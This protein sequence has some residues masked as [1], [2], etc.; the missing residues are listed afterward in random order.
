MSLIIQPQHNDEQSSV[1]RTIGARMSNKAKRKL[2]KKGAKAAAKIVK[3]AA[4]S[5]GSLLLKMF[6]TLVSFLGLPIILFALA[7]VV[8]VVVSSLAFSFF[9]TTGEG[10]QGED[11]A[12]Y[13]YIVKKANSTVDMNNEW[14]RPYRVPEGLIAATI[15]LDV[16]K[17]DDI[18]ELIDTMAEKLAPVFE[19]GE[20][21]EWT[22]TYQKIYEDGKL[23]KTTEVKRKDNWVKKLDRADY[24]NGNTTFT[25][26]PHVTPWESSEKITYR[27]EKYTETVIETYI[28]YVEETYYEY[29]WVPY[30]V[31]KLVSYT[32][33]V[34]VIDENGVPRLVPVTKYK[35]EIVIEYR[36]EKVEKKRT[37][38]V[39][40]QREVE[41][42]KTRKIE[43]KTVTY[44]RKQYFTS[45]QK[46]VTDYSNFDNVLNSFNLGTIDKKIIEANYAF[47]GG[48]INYIEWLEN[49]G[50]ISDDYVYYD[51]TVIPGESVPAQFMEFYRSAEKKYGVPWYVLAA[52]HFVET[53]FST[54]PTMISSAGAIGPMQF[55]PATWVGWKYS[56]GRGFVSPDIDITDISLIEKGGGYGVDANGDGKADPWDEADAIHAA[57]KMLKA[58]GFTKN[59]RGAIRKYNNSTV[60]VDTVL[61]YAEQFKYEASYVGGD[62]V[63]SL[64][65]GGFMRPAFGK[66]TSPFGVRILNGRR[67]IHYGV[68]IAAEGNVKIVAAADGVVSRSY[69]SSSYGEVV[70]IKHNINGQAYETVYAHMVKGSRAVKEGQK[71]KQGQFLG[72]M[73]ATG[74]VTGKHLHFEIHQGSWNISKSNAIN[75]ALLIK[76]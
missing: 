37:V 19:Y 45:S 69:Y 75:P 22:E 20:Y 34:L 47:T 74:D 65:P 8:I 39:E 63:P 61:K 31:E 55:L 66:V 64:N 48:T 56:I 49:N 60:Y 53:G 23:V 29:E 50:L 4:V 7:A 68:D 14:E 16:I 24:W 51:G 11:K 62:G 41:V 36:Y 30:E 10:L 21:N 35:K 12:I 71:V 44:T 33:Y 25:Y 9:F 58:N 1:A 27:E 59:P 2:L 73:G 42:E 54:H 13:E 70:F 18:K 46:S 67:S 3:N 38:P 72:Y 76:F 32:E 26:T 57:A 28:E 17:T 43:V 52:I 6:V 15:Q 5:L 40:R